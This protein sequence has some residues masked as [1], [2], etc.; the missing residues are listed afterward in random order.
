MKGWLYKQEK[1]LRTSWKKY[2]VEVSNGQMKGFKS[3]NVGNASISLL[4]KWWLIDCDV[5]CETSRIQMLSL[6]WT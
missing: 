6:L 4:F 5:L 3:Q 2:W 1:S